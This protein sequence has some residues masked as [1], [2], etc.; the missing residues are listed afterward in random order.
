M[1]KRIFVF[2]LF[3]FIIRL[4]FGLCS[5]FWF[6]DE[7]QVYLLG[8]KFFT[9]KS[10]PYFGPDIVYTHSQLPGALQALLVGLPFFAL[11]IPEAPYIFLNILSTGSLV[12]F[13]WYCT[14]LFNIPWWI[15][16][17]LILFAP[18]TLNYSTHII[19]P[20]YVLPA[21]VLFF[22]SFFEL[23]P[24]TKKNI[25]SPRIC[26]ALMGFSLFWI[27]QLHMSWVLL[28]PIILFSFYIKFSFK[29]VLWFLIGSSVMLVLVIPTYIEY[30]FLGTGGTGS[31]L[32]FNYKNAGE[33]FTV[34]F[35]FLSLPCM[36]LPRF[37]GSNTDERFSLLLK[38]AWVIPFAF[39]VAIS[40]MLQPLS[41]I[42]EFFR[43][44]KNSKT[45]WRF[46]KYF[47]LAV[48]VMLY[49]SF[50]FSVKG[51][52]SHT[53]YVLY[54]LTVIYA[55][56]C[57]EKYLQ[58]PLWKKFVFVLIV[59]CVLVHIVIA[60]NGFKMRSM[61]ADTPHGNGRMLTLKAI[62]EQR[63]EVLGSRRDGVKY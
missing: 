48:F 25:L 41:L 26:F 53:F 50:L 24:E 52:S 18:W 43:A 14:K 1:N 15:V 2:I 59:S 27:Y 3:A 20:S 40:G 30:G 56:Y 22:I 35:R 7:L 46:V 63:Y 54:P 31:N 10:W 37:L 8:L 29:N 38:Y 17:S 44:G 12:F 51:P 60:L 32:T 34:F 16:F 61:Y 9:L 4:A 39:I 19:N 45:A 58:R 21:A 23:M 13:A 33:F 5:E 42:F 11:P 28:V 47:T 57:W 6:E 62:Q 55:F 36:E 49:L